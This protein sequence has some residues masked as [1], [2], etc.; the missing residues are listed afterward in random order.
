[1]GTCPRAVRPCLRHEDIDKLV[2]QL[3]S[4][5]VGGLLATPVKDTLKRVDHLG[6][7]SVTLDRKDVWQALTPQMFRLDKLNQAL[8]NAIEKQQPV[9]D[10]ASAVER[11]GGD[12]PLIVEGRHDN[13]KITYPNDLALAENILRLTC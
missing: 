11:M 5:P 13:I 2:E 3:R 4:H 12:M 6:N 10:E 1:M 8:R 9:T 7:V